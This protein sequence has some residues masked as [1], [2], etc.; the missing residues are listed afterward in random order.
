MLEDL[1]WTSLKDRR[2]AH[3]LT[4]LYKIHHDLLDI[5][6]TYTT[7]KTDRA[8]RGHNQ[9]F[10]L[11]NTKLAPFTNSFFPRT[12]KDWNNL[13]QITINQASMNT[14]KKSIPL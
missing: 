8:R 5:P 13:P 2:R 4:C 14:F 12:I 9:Q 3:R 6:K 11:Y 10:Q 1:N 7:P